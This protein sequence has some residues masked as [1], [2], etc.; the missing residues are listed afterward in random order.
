MNSKELRLEPNSSDEEP[1]SGT[2]HEFNPLNAPIPHRSPVPRPPQPI[3][4]P[5]VD[6]RRNPDFK[7]KVLGIHGEEIEL[8]YRLQLTP[9]HPGG[10]LDWMPFRI[11]YPGWTPPRGPAFVSDPRP[12]FRPPFVPPQPAP[13][14]PPPPPQP[15][16]P[17]PRPDVPISGRPGPSTNNQLPVQ[18]QEKTQESEAAESDWKHI[19]RQYQLDLYQAAR[20]RNIIAFLDTGAGKTFISVLLIRDIA[21]RAERFAKMENVPKKPI[22]FLVPSKVLVQQ[23]AEVLRK[24]TDLQI[25]QHTGDRKNED[26]WDGTTWNAYVQ[27]AHVLVMTPQILLN[28]LRK[29]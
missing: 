12:M 16:R 23:Q 22:F 27:E 2:R 17:M 11:P 8:F 19:A 3:S 1:D 6:L 26:V 24:H 15:V 10:P 5:E 21:A 4:I 25:S 9:I 20:R 7:V 14:L 18:E 29:Q 13:V 28:M